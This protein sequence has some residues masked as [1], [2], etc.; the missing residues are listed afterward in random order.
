MSRLLAF[1]ALMMPLLLAAQESSRTAPNA[2]PDGIMDVHGS[3]NLGADREAPV[4]GLM[5]IQRIDKVNRLI[6]QNAFRTAATELEELTNLPRL[7]PLEIAVIDELTGFVYGQ[8]N[9]TGLAIEHYQRA[10]ESKALPTPMHQGAQYSLAH[11]HAANSDYVSAIELMVDWFQ[12]QPDPFAESFMFM[13]SNY[14]ALEQYAD[15]LPWVERAIERAERP[16]EDW[17]QITYSIHIEL[18]RYDKA[19]AMLKTMLRYWSQ[20]PEYWE[21]LAALYQE[22]GENKA[23]HDTK[24]TAYINGMLRTEQSILSLVDMSLIY[25][26]P[27]AA[28]TILENEM[29]AGVV[30]ERE[31]TLVILVDIWIAARE[32][33][34]A[35]AAIDKLAAYTNPGPNYMRAA[36]LYVQSGDFAGAAASAEKALAADI[37]DRIAAL[38]VAG[39]AFAE[40]GEWDKSIAAFREVA[41]IGND[42]E[43]DNAGNWIRYVE[44]SRQLRL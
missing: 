19:I 40:L 1:V 15:S 23:A 32:Y 21:A 4:I 27:F 30:A 20:V 13:G 7:S 6:D 36:Q 11:L 31:Q 17:Y 24:M 44:E 35:I 33:D 10:L 29:F 8:M 2:D 43:R 18:G 14:A 39:S 41:N 9:E 5:L 16:I 3:R 38:V 12:F 25:D 42:D 37:D 26:T 28:G 22:T 34:K